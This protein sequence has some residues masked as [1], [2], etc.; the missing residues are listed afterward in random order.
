MTELKFI[1][2]PNI[3][4]NTNYNVFESIMGNEYIVIDWTMGNT[5]NYHCTYCPDWINDGSVGWPELE[6]FENFIEKCTSHYKS[7]GKKLVWNL[8]GGE[9][10]VWKYFTEACSIIK[11]YD[12]DSG[13][14]ILT[15][16]SRTLRWWEKNGH[17]FDEVIISYHPENADYIHCCEV[18][19]ILYKHG[20]NVSIQ[21]CL[22]PPLFETCLAAAEHYHNNSYSNS[23][24]IKALQEVLGSPKTFDYDKEKL[25]QIEKYSGLPRLRK[26][27][28]QEEK[29]IE[30]K[31]LRRFYGKMMRFIDTNTGKQEVFD[32]ISEL[33]IDGRNTFKGWHCN[34]GIDTLNIDMF[35]NVTSGSSCNHHI[36]HGN[37]KDVTNINFPTS[38]LICEYDWCSCLQDVEASK[39][40]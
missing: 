2:K 35:G 24:L 13:I 31:F 25:A 17:F 38:G 6:D 21:V 3:E 8:L 34:I 7:I 40:R 23:I 28:D 11:K 33:M 27:Q 4:A 20:V 1:S 19:N 30:Q 36:N 14:R 32:S 10:T 22:Y 15:N 29:S 37:V 26:L 18:S 12:P 9:P 16:G 39:Y 5:C